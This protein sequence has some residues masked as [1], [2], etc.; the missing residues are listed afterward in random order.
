MK[1]TLD[2]E[3]KYVYR[4]LVKSYYQLLMFRLSKQCGF[5]HRLRVVEVVLG[6]PIGNA[7]R[8]NHLLCQCITVQLHQRRL[9][10]HG[11]Q[12]RRESSH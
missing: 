6:Y 8:T 3:I 11:L 5:V 4:S 2:S 12:I 7:S 10:L 9:L 1:T